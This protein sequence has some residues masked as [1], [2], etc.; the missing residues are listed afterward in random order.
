MRTFRPTSACTSCSSSSG[1]LWLKPLTFSSMPAMPSGHACS[2]PVPQDA[3]HTM[4]CMKP[5]QQTQTTR[6]PDRHAHF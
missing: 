4:T 3:S 5:L 2:P 1:S 6:R